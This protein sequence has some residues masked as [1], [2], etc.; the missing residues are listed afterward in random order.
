VP[1]L[2]A[3][4]ILN[5]VV[6]ANGA[7]YVV[8]VDGEFSLVFGTSASSPTFSAVLANI[9]DARLAIGKKPLGFVNP[10]L[11]SSGF[12]VAF[13]VCSADASCCAEIDPHTGHH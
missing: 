2:L 8:A 12:Q 11:Y 13:N 6:S 3:R 1:L 5:C 10:S 7:N 4:S 9:N